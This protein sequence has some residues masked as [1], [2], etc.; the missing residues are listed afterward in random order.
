MPCFH[1]AV[2]TLHSTRV[3]R[4]V[5]EKR[6]VPTPPPRVDRK[7]EEKRGV[8]TPPPLARL[9]SGDLQQEAQLDS[10]FVTLATSRLAH[11]PTSLS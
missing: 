8:P 3:D 10:Q 4:K 5:E 1:S 9:S 11:P 7:V 6:G 2:S